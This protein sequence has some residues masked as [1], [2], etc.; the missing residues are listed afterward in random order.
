MKIIIPSEENNLQS[1]TSQVF[2]RAPFFLLFQ[3]SGK[4]YKLLESIENPSANAQGGVG[5]MTAKLIAEKEADVLMT[6]E[7]GPRAK[8]ALEQ[9]KIKILNAQA[10]VLESISNFIN[11]KN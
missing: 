9:F 3:V 1:K 5:A 6:H 8:D 11:I 10:T 7:I 2:G 4:E